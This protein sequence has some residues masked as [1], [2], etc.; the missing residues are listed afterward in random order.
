MEEIAG[1]L[2]TTLVH[3]GKLPDISKNQIFV[4]EFKITGEKQIELNVEIHEKLKGN[5]PEAKKPYQVGSW[6]DPELDK[7]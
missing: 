5:T 6:K 2:L 1:P 4:W 3:R 7:V